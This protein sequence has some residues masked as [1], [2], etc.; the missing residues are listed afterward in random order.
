MLTHS[1]TKNSELFASERVILQTNF[2]DIDALK[3]A[4]PLCCYKTA[5]V[6]IDVLI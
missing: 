6:L 4:V 3:D 2:Q 5:V 1:Q